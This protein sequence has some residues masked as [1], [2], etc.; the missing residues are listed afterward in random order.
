LCGYGAWNETP[1]RSHRL[2]FCLWHREGSLA[3]AGKPRLLAEILF[4]RLGCALLL[5]VP[6][7]LLLFRRWQRGSFSVFFAAVVAQPTKPGILS[8]T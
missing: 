7:I 5:I 1:G 3:G 6:A 2:R 8:R 4:R